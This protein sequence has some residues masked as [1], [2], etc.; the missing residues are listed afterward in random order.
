MAKFHDR[1]EVLPHGSVHEVAPGILTV[2][3][4]IPMPLGNF[5]RRMTVVAI[6]RKRSAVFSPIPLRANSMAEI[7]AIG[8]PD[9][10]IVPNGGHRLDLRSFHTRYPKAKIV[11]APGSKGR[12]EEAVRP[13][14]TRATLGRH[15]RLLT[16]AGCDGRELALRI[17]QDDEVTLITN[18][19]IGHVGYPEGFGAKVMSRLLGFGPQ[20]RVT[21]P[22]K[23]FFIKDKAALAAQ[24]LQWARIRGLRRL[25]PSHGDIVDRPGPLLERLAKSLD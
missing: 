12:V 15:V 24:F 3:G 10:L 6:G 18:D 22:A 14:Q 5:P 7:E 11:T 21:R 1:W 9:Y 8:T 4:Q 19:I 2:V 25:I 20:A 23:W 16:L 13:V 17:D